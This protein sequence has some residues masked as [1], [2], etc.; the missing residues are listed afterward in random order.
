MLKRLFFRLSLL[1][2]AGFLVT[3]CSPSSDPSK[4]EITS[5]CVSSGGNINDPCLKRP[6]EGNL[7][8]L[9]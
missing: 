6:I 8:Y 3:G 9:S 2:A 7:P 4:R 1:L 5:P